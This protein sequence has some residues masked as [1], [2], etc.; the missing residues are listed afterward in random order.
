MEQVNHNKRRNVVVNRRHEIPAAKTL[1]SDML[2]LCSYQMQG[3]GFNVGPL[4][5]R[6]FDFDGHCNDMG[7][8]EIFF[9]S[10]IGYENFD[11]IGAFFCLFPYGDFARRLIDSK[12]L[13]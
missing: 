10:F 4:S 6:L 7:Y 3:R 9:V 2:L 1:Q 12:G 11:F 13:E 8:S 5:D